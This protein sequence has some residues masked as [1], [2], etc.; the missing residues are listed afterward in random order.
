MVVRAAMSFHQDMSGE[1]PS[2]KE[3]FGEEK[4]DVFRELSYLE[5]IP[6]NSKGGEIT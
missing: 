3:T 1:T 2:K 5:L 4:K 6:K